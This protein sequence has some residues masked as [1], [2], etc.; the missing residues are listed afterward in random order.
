MANETETTVTDEQLV[1]WEDACEQAT[2]G[3]WCFT[4][5]GEKVADYSLGV[6][7]STADDAD[8]EKNL[9]GFQEPDDVEFD[10]RLCYRESAEGSNAS[11]DF[12]FIALARTA[13]PQLIALVR[14]LRTAAGEMEGERDAW[15]RNAEE[16]EQKLQRERNRLDWLEQREGPFANIDRITS[17]DGKFDR[18]PSLRA[19]ID[20]AMATDQEAPHVPR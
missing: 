4:V 12:A 14:R 18:L 16:W 11:S 17:V 9:E 2:P 8:F 3:P 6:G 1:E 7:Y 5:E 13:M 20:A 15:K 19:A 10:E